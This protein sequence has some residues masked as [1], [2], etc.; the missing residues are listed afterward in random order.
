MQ[1]AILASG[2]SL[3]V[4]QPKHLQFV[5]IGKCRLITSH[6]NLKMAMETGIITCWPTGTGPYNDRTVVFS[7][8][9][10]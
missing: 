4:E 5:R 9:V 7:A 10:Y 1:H 2:R 8:K 6:T 3:V